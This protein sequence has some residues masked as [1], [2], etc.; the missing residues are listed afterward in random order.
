MKYVIYIKMLVKIKSEIWVIS[1]VYFM[2]LFASWLQNDINILLSQRHLK[3]FSN[4]LPAI[5]R[6]YLKMYIATR[7]APLAEAAS[8]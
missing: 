8:R 4:K 6:L 2:Q 1:F 7:P 5:L 3:R